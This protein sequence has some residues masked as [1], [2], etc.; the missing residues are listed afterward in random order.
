MLSVHML[1]RS[2]ITHIGVLTLG[3]RL[4]GLLVV[5][6]VARALPLVALLLLRLALLL[7]LLLLLLLALVSRL[8][9]LLLMLL[10]LVRHCLRESGGELQMRSKDFVI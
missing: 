4:V 9:L 1:I 3:G 8:L 6:A 7:V 5:A 2:F 10:L